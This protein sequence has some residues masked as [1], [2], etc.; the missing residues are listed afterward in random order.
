MNISTT[1][2]NMKNERDIL[3]ELIQ[4]SLAGKIDPSSN[5]NPADFADAIVTK[6][7]LNRTL[8]ERN[9]K[10]VE[11]AVQAFNESINE[12]DKDMDIEL[13]QMGKDEVLLKNFVRGQKEACEKLRSSLENI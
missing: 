1:H 12:I 13:E 5:F 9:A 3:I 4:A 11:D 7:D 2:I 6:L 8:E 10:K